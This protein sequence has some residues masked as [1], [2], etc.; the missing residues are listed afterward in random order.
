MK[1]FDDTN[2]DS[3][4]DASIE[5]ALNTFIGNYDN[6]LTGGS[7]VQEYYQD[8]RS[9]SIMTDLYTILAKITIADEFFRNINED[10]EDI[11]RDLRDHADNNDDGTL[12]D[13]EFDSA[14]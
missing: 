3:D 5:G 10:A 11:I 1:S 12:F 4:L 7:T 9:E 13:A 6:I 8:F 14:M 2:S